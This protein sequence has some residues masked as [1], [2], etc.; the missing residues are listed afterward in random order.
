MLIVI[1]ICKL[2][3]C[4]KMSTSSHATHR[5]RILMAADAIYHL[6]LERFTITYARPHLGLFLSQSDN[7]FQDATDLGILNSGF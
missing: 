2:D 1:T 3:R 4:S 7:L 6:S 5:M